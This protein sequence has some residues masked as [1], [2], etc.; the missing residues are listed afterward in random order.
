MT[1]GESRVYLTVACD[2]V[3]MH[4]KEPVR[5]VFE[6]QAR[7]GPAP[8]DREKALVWSL[9]TALRTGSV[10]PFTEYYT[11]ILQQV[12]ISDALRPFMPR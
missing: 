10:K 9:P 3:L 1:S 4:V 6:T 7:I 2:L 12:A 11:L 5:F 8:Q